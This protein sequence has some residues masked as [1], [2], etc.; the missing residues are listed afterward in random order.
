VEVKVKGVSSWLCLLRYYDAGQ[1][2]I[3]HANGLPNLRSEPHTSARVSKCKTAYQQIQT[4]RSLKHWT[5]VKWEMQVATQQTQDSCRYGPQDY[6][7]EV[8][9]VKT[10]VSASS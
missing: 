10:L 3:K 7:L 2:N 9:D 1:Q 6:S 4:P 5:D 8:A